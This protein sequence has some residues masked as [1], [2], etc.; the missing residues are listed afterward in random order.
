MNRLKRIE[1]QFP[2]NYL[3]KKYDLKYYLLGTLINEQGNILCII[4]I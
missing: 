2:A 4:T 3:R 1:D